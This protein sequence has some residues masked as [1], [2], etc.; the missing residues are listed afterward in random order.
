M[1][2]AS[3]WCLDPSVTY[4]NHG[5]FGACPHPASVAHFRVRDDADSVGSELPRGNRVLGIGGIAESKLAAAALSR[6]DS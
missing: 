3:L 1:N 2:L 6:P 5:S 4:L